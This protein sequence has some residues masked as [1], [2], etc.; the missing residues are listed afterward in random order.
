MRCLPNKQLL[1]KMKLVISFLAFLAM[2]AAEDGPAVRASSFFLL[3]FFEIQSSCVTV[4]PDLFPMDGWMT[5]DSTF[6]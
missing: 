1:K 4:L 6:H 5:D 3:G 2:A